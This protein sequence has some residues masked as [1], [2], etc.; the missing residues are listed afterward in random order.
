MTV[1]LSNYLCLDKE[2]LLWSVTK[3]KDS[4]PVCLVAPSQGSALA[5]LWETAA[6]LQKGEKWAPRGLSEQVLAFSPV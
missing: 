3:V 2:S 1:R 6:F 4:L 5:T